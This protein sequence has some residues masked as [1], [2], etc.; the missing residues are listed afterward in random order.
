MIT[1]QLEWS[2]NKQFRTQEDWQMF[3]PFGCLSNTSMESVKRLCP[4]AVLVIN[5]LGA[6]SCCHG[7][8]VFVFAII[9]SAKENQWQ[10]L[11]EREL[12]WITFQFYNF[13]KFTIFRFQCNQLMCSLY[14]TVTPAVLMS[15]FKGVCNLIGHKKQEW[16]MFSVCNRS[17]VFILCVRSNVIFNVH[18][19]APFCLQCIGSIRLTLWI[20]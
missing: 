1:E 15:T 20:S 14:H 16:E 12:V 18:L 4:Q 8:P 13:A 2:N 9:V 7:H 5:R 10:T 11:G 17:E 3:L 19:S 6:A